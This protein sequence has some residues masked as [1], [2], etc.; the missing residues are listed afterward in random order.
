[1]Q[2]EKLNLND[3]KIEFNLLDLNLDNQKGLITNIFNREYN[4]I[5]KK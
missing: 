1:M 4:E 5:N 2:N 3:Y